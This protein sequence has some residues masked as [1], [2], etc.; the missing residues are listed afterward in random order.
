[1]NHNLSSKKADAQSRLKIELACVEHAIFERFSGLKIGDT[2]KIFDVPILLNGKKE[3]IHTIRAGDTKKEDLVLIHG[4]FSEVTAFVKLIKDLSQHYRVW[5]FDLI[6]MGSSSRPEFTCQSTEETIEYFVDSIE[7][8]RE[9]VGLDKFYLLGHSFGG[10]MSTMYALEHAE[11]VK[12]L[13]LSSPGGVTR[14]D[15]NEAV[16]KMLNSKPWFQKQVAKIFL[17]FWEKK[18]PTPHSVAKQCGFLR[19]IVLKMLAKKAAL[20]DGEAELKLRYNQI[21]LQLPESTM[22][23]VHYLFTMSPKGAGFL[24]L[25]DKMHL[26]KMPCEIYFGEKDWMDREGAYR[27]VANGAING[28][29]HTIPGAGHNLY[30]HHSKYISQLLI[31]RLLPL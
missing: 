28:D 17:S 8:W 23:S 6:G 15:T 29:I 10:Y 13:I 5:C 12:K 18:K 3:S 31:Y 1:M 22:K 16:S 27:V 19:D 2:L 7:Q 4:Y 24:P 20:A 25:E 9:K 30:L 26:L 21:I 14:P 11:H